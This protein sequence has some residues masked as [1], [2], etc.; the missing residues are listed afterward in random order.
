M[1]DYVSNTGFRIFVVLNPVAG[2][3]DAATIRQMI[4]R[5]LGEDGGTAEIYETTG[6]EDL[7]AIVQ[8]ACEKEPDLVV[9]AGGDGT[10]AGVISGL[11]GSEIPLAILPA[12]TG[13]GLARALSIPL[14]LEEAAGLLVSEHRLTDVD[15]M[16]VDDRHYVLN[17]SAG[18]SSRAM[19]ATRVEEKRRFGI[20]AYVWTLLKELT[21]YQP[22]WY[23]LLLEDQTMRVRASEVIVTNAT[24]L[25]N[26]RFTFG[27]R[28]DLSDGC[29][30]VYIITARNVLDYLILVWQTLISAND[31]RSKLKTFEISSSITIETPGSALPVQ[32]DGE[33][34]GTTPVTVDL[35]PAALQVIVPKVQ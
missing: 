29:L 3:A 21:G 23:R 7:V 24:H 20:L 14:S 19:R 31:R 27:S 17:V 15:V 4:D 35:L 26:S 34:L 12:G 5:Q 18:I 8:G 2:G 16:R 22:R 11:V 32:A 25:K 28:E 6:D 33:P 13:N 30:D 1:S 9:V 10:V